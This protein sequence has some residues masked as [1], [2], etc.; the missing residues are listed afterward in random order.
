MRGDNYR[1]DKI[2]SNNT[3]RT[4]IHVQ[5]TKDADLTCIYTVK[6]SS[7]LFAL[8]STRPPCR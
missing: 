1:R 8:C 2:V 4:M 5:I 3:S 6:N 7:I